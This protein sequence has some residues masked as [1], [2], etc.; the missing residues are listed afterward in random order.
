[1]QLESITLRM[2]DY[3]INVV[4]SLTLI[5]YFGCGFA[6][7]ISNSVVGASPMVMMTATFSFGGKFMMTPKAFKNDFVVKWRY[8][9]KLER[10]A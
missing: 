4:K 3:L 9:H 5:L 1:M 2:M 10:R 8:T 6:A 7:A